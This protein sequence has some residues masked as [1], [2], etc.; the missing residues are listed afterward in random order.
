[1]SPDSQPPAPPYSQAEGTPTYPQPT[2]ATQDTPMDT[3]DTLPESEMTTGDQRTTENPDTNAGQQ[4][5][6]EELAMTQQETTH[7][8]IPR[9]LHFRKD[10]HAN[11]PPAQTSTVAH[12]SQQVLPATTPSQSAMQ[13]QGAP[14]SE[15]QPEAM[16]VDREGGRE[17]NTPLPG[18]SNPQPPPP[19]TPAA[20]ESAFAPA[21]A[22]GFPYTQL[23]TDPTFLLS[24]DTLT[25]CE[26]KPFPKMWARLWRGGYNEEK[27]ADN[28]TGQ[29]P[30]ITIPTRDSKA[31]RGRNHNDKAYNPPYHFLIYGISEEACDALLTARAVST[32]DTQAFFVP[33][34]PT[35]PHFICTIQGFMFDIFVDESSPESNLNVDETVLTI[36]QKA[37]RNDTEFEHLI[38]TR[39]TSGASHETFIKALTVVSHLAMSLKTKETTPTPRPSRCPSKQRRR[40][41]RPAQERNEVEPILPPPPP[42][43]T[44][45]FFSQKK[46]ND[47]DWGRGHPLVGDA[48]Y[49]C[50]N[51][52][53][54]DHVSKQCVYLTVPGWHRVAAGEEALTTIEHADQAPQSQDPHHRGGGSDSWRV[55]AGGDQRGS[56]TDPS[57]QNDT[58][59]RSIARNN[60][61]KRRR[62]A[63]TVATLNMRGGGSTA[64]KTKWTTINQMLRDERLDVLVLQETHLTD[65][66]TDEL[67]RMFTKRMNIINTTDDTNTRAIGTAVILNK[68]T[69]RWKDA[70]YDVIVPGRALRMQVPWTENEDFTCLVIY[71]PNDTGQNTDFWNEIHET[72]ARRRWKKPTC[73]LGDLN[74]VEDSLDRLPPRRDSPEQA[75]ALQD[76]KIYLQLADGW[77]RENPQKI[78]FSFKADGRL[79]HSRIDRIYVREEL[80]PYTHGWN[81]R[82]S[83]VKTDHLLVSMRILNPKAP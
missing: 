7:S 64:T 45:Q 77:R 19:T 60:N 18:N 29:R 37:L 6:N 62:G 23:G 34:H 55:T 33:Y 35:T 47:M 82:R 83:A 53:A 30:R 14:N 39:C 2:Q 42:A 57:T 38:R 69:M 65:D 1:M 44:R 27:Q 5:P 80:I 43:Q 61:Q 70:K 41:Q 73:M 63:L 67:N 74:M 68:E 16:L 32:K 22:N 9:D 36:V 15:S 52:K 75:Q 72:W 8:Q 59:P 25:T 76:L 56:Q 24:D 40:P 66:L 11:P 78:D 51:C 17:D 54:T 79:I 49:H 71:A 81:I 13:Q 10:K 3:S 50:V 48:K 26:A 20:N 21:P 12:A 4:T 31:K 58:T 46:Y 28:R